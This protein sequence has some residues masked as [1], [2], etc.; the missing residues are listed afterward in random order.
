MAKENRLVKYL[1]ESKAEIKKVSWPTKKNTLAY[2]LGVIAITLSVAFFL[3]G[4]DFVFSYLVS[5]VV[6]K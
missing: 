2:S 5:L 3:G 6:V 1:Q 4:L